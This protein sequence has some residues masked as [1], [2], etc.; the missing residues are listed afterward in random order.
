VLAGQAGIKDHVS[1]GDGA[2][3][4]AQGGVIGDVPAGV[5][6]SGYPARPHAE[7]M[8]ELGALAALPDALKRLRAQERRLAACEA[9]LGQTPLQ[10]DT[11]P[12]DA[13]ASDVGDPGERSAES[14]RASQ[15]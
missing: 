3:V 9:A 2:R 10:G 5:T 7:K 8:R 12:D 11:V 15:V 13:A 4:G 1:L 6:V 14:R